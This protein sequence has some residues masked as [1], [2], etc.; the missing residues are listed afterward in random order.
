MPNAVAKIAIYNARFTTPRL[1]RVLDGDFSADW[2]Y[3]AD[4]RQWVT[5]VTAAVEALGW[6]VVTVSLATREH[7]HDVVVTVYEAG[8]SPAA[9]AQQK[10][11]T[12]T[13]GGRPVGAVDSAGRTMAGARRDLHPS[14]TGR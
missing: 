6:E 10:R 4:R 5:R 2:L 13:V 7:T 12:A 14:R 1:E 8:G 11:R 9:Q 3:R